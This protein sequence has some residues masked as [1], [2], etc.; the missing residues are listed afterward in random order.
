MKHFEIEENVLI[1]MYTLDEVRALY[2]LSEVCLYPSTAAEPFGLT[3]LEAMAMEKPM[4]VTNMGGMPEVIRDGINGFIVPVRDFEMLAAKIC[5][6]LED[7][8]LLKIYMPIL[9]A[10]FKIL[11]DY[12]FDSFSNKFNCDITVLY[13]NEDTSLKYDELLE[14]KIYTTKNF[15]IINYDGDHLFLNKNMYE[16]IYLINN[17]LRHS[18]ISTK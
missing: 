11:E 8:K 14:W 7:E 17:S 6:L 5:Q 4:I 1:D 9:K 16:I 2:E 13:G 10:D 15:K 12:S 18:L 3:M